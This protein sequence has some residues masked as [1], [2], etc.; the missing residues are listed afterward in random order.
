MSVRKGIV[1]AGGS[2]SR[3]YPTTLGVCKQLL[4]VYDK[5]MIYYPLCTLML[6][7]IRE[8][9][10]ISTPQDVPRFRQV[11]G[12]GGQWGVSIEYIVQDHP[13]GLAEA[14]IL[15]EEFL[16]GEPCSLI[17]GDNI[18]FGSGLSGMLQHVSGQA[19]GATVFAY[20]V[21]NP[22]A[23]GVVEFDAEQKALSIEEK[24]I[25]PRSRYAV[26]GLYFYD[27]QVVGMARALTP[28]QRGEL[29]IT[30]I[31]RIYLER[32]ELDVR[33]LARGTAWL[34]TGTT[35]ALLEAAHFIQTL[36]KRQGMKVGC[37]E[38]VAWRMGW[39]DDDG[40][41]QLAGPLIKSGYGEYLLELLEHPV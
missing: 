20:P 5:P 16:A 22:E 14:F 18:F 29:E 31:N 13:R 33:R 8:I 32:G 40:L 34:D 1:L 9:L 15:G 41:R 35:D 7:G 3:L 39:I 26:T 12:G 4:P 28:S 10:V 17:L 30:D 6:A 38:E 2:G 23:F 36:E 37:P 24:P 19:A 21:G 25:R 11:L 27:E